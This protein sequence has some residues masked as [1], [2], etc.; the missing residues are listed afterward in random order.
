MN[1]E[2]S[3]ALI[4]VGWV[5][6]VMMI[7]ALVLYPYESYQFTGLGISNGVNLYACRYAEPAPMG[8]V[9]YGVSSYGNIYNI[10][11]NSIEG[12]ITLDGLLVNLSG[13][14]NASV[15]LNAN[16]FLGYGNKTQ[17]YFIQNVILLN[18]KTYAASFIDNVWNDSGINA[19]LNGSIIKGQGNV[20]PS[21]K[22]ETYYFYQAANLTG[23]NMTLKNAQTIYLRTNSSMTE[24][25]T[26]EIIFSYNDGYGWITYDRV[27]I[28]ANESVKNSSILISGF[29]Y[30][31]SYNFYDMGL[32]I[33][34]PGNGYNT[35][36]ESGSAAFT[37]GYWNNNNFQNVQDSYNFGCNTEE[38][39]NNTVVTPMF[40]GDG[41][42][43]ANVSSG[44]NVYLGGLWSMNSSN[45]SLV[46]ING[47]GAGMTVSFERNG[48][49]FNT[50][51]E[52]GIGEFTL[53]S[54][55][56]IITA[57]SNV[58]MIY[59]QNYTLIAGESKYI[60]IS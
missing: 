10:S 57:Y 4:L 13:N 7:A 37:L 41:L 1:N 17:S 25:G 53:E 5:L 60:N 44:N 45:I 18:T 43:Y 27:Q 51:L 12:G 55:E 58:T 54:G 30:T 24:N 42:L 39:I 28:L 21:Q 35:T 34:G 56:Y 9:D 38:G 36:L 46:Y 23:D 29:N 19:S 15:Q 31:P 26:P 33:G 59:R 47:P 48:S 50:S 40:Y 2:K 11:T 16:L 49:G 14:Y 8:I 32:V 22:N 3:E 52:K 20:T 6:A